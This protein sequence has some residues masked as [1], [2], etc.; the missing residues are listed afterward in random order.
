MVKGL[1]A[2]KLGMMSLFSSDGK[3]IPVTV[4]EV[5]PCKVIQIKT[6][7]SDGYNALQI[8]F[9]DKKISKTNKPLLGHFKKAGNETAYR[10]LKEFKVEDSDEYSVGDKISVDL[11][12]I[13]ERVNIVGTTKG[14]G[15]TGVIKR[16]GFKGGKATHGSTTY[17]RPGSIGCSAW[18]AKVARGKKMPGHYGVDRQTI[19]NLKI[20]DIRPD[21]N[22]I[23]I[24][25]AVP[26]AKSG[27]VEIKKLEFVK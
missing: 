9:I 3:W 26:G 1:I 22:L 21:E 16:H 2:K 5:G 19:K 23:M 17:R 10:F 8:G 7:K 12:N 13:G 18:P 15:F 4:L 20:V 6:E 14:R 24:K 25:G 27:I 11:F